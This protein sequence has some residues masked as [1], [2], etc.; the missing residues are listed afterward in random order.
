MWQE[1]SITSDIA[2]QEAPV[3]SEVSVAEGEDSG[4]GKSGGGL[5]GMFRGSKPTDST[6]APSRAASRLSSVDNTQFRK[7]SYVSPEFLGAEGA[8]K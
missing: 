5:F 7:F 6:T 4:K 3:F 1:L 2:V 8:F